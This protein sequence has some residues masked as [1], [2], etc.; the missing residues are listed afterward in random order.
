MTALDQEQDVID[1][2][3]RLGLCGTPVEAIINFCQ[4]QIDSW[5][6][7]AGGVDSIDK[8]ETLV[9]CRLNLIFE[10][11]WNDADLDD[12]KE[13][14]VQKG[15]IVFAHIVQNDLT[16]E[17]FG[18]MVRLKDGSHVAVIDC[19]GEKAA[20]RFFTRWHEISH[21]LVEPDCEQQV[22]RETDE[23][24]EKLMDQ[25]A[26]RVGFYP[27]IFEPIFAQNLPSGKLLTFDVVES[28]RQSFCPHA[29]FQST[30][31]ACLRRVS[32]PILYL[33]ARLAY[34]ESERRGLKQ[35]RMFDDDKPEKKL[36]V[37]LSIPNDAAS[38]M[39]LKTH[40]NMRVPE[41]SQ[42]YSAF[43]NI[44]EE[45]SGVENLN[46]WTF[47]KGGYLLDCEVFVQARRVDQFVM[48]TIQPIPQ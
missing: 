15:E 19:R 26:G 23:P 48:A 22:F 21:L 31:F 46:T 12:L 7:E 3:T 42:I 11:V 9:S 20:R 2:A 24:L 38:D 8:L 1:L 13:R 34:S 14:Y 29:S 25:I 45:K 28:V 18:T 10:E 30:L 27:S 4:K 17:T 40:W 16:S 43:S 33:E 35:L 44:E 47:S 32:M 5:V 41:S 6:E 36:R 37:Q 39:K